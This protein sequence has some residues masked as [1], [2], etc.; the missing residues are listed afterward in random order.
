MTGFALF[1]KQV[2]LFLFNAIFSGTPLMYGTMGEILT[3]KSGNM[4]LG[5]EGMMFMGGAFGL[6]GAYYYEKAC[7]NA[8]TT[9]L[10]W[11]AIL[12][13]VLSAFAAGALGALI[14]GFITITLRA[15]QN[16]T[17][18]ALTIFGTGAAQFMGE[19]MRINEGGFVSL[20][21]NLKDAFV[22]LFQVD[23]FKNPETLKDCLL[24]L[25]FGHSIFVYAGILL[26][27]FLTLFIKYTR[28]GLNL[29]SV[30]ESPQT[31]DAAGINVIRYKYIATTVGGGISALGGMIYIA[32]NAGCVWNHN[33]LSGL[34]WLSVA[35]VIFC[36]WRPVNAIWGSMVFGGLTIL[37]Q[38]LSL[39]I[40]SEL[41]KILPY[42]VTVIVLILTSIRK[43][44]ENQPPESLGNAYF[45]EDR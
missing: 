19:F 8:G 22:S 26:A 45:R 31:A 11:L 43:K 20:G 35:L 18:L 38:R 13:A 36:L 34:G 6:A 33:A 7:I 14:F 16:V 28:W 21:N 37:Y 27:V 23:A 2:L 39:P 10:P 42:V 30:G 25:F 41:Y 9:V 4:N 29:R 5:V 15:N 40:P 3:Q 12:I 17:G 24:K 32:V 44:K 1:M